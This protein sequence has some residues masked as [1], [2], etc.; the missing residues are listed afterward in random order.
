MCETE[1]NDLEDIK[2]HDENYEVSTKS[3]TIGELN[4][5]STCPDCEYVKVVF[6]AKNT[7]VKV[8]FDPKNTVVGPLGY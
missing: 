8:M 4:N 3:E 7:Y 6:D 1:R 2:L 5:V